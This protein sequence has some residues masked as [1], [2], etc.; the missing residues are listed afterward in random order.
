MKKLMIIALLAL[1]AGCGARK[2]DVQQSTEEIDLK[3]SGDTIAHVVEHA[4]VKEL[5][6]EREASEVHRS[7]AG[8]EVG[9]GGSVTITEFDKDGKKTRE[10]QMKDNGRATDSNEQ[11]KSEQT[12]SKQKNEATAKTTAASGSHAIEVKGSEK[13]K[14][15]QMKRD[16]LSLLPL[17][18]SCVS[19]AA[20][21]L[22]CLWIRKKIRNENNKHNPA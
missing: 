7:L 18:I 15:I 12:S 5:T 9:P 6:E 19:G 14:D 17:I 20:A 10:T 8:I 21:F 2:K 3:A 11:S 22:F 13:N 16:G 1:M 4:A